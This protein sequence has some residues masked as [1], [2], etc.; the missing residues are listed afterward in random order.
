LYFT[1]WQLLFSL[2]AFLWERHCGEMGIFR[3]NLPPANRQR[4][5]AVVAITSCLFALA[6]WAYVLAFDTVGS[7]NAA[8]AIQVYPLFATGL[9][10]AFLRR[11]KSLVE[12]LFTLLIIAALFHLATGGE[13]RM[14]GVSPW[15]AVAL[16]VPTLWSIA[17]V[18]LRQVLV[19]TPITPH[20]VTCLRL[21]VSSLCLLPL[22]LAV[23]GVDAVMVAA[24]HG[25]AQAS[26]LLMGFVYYLELVLWFYAV[27]HID[28]SV[29][30]A[31]I[32]P[33]PAVTL[34]LT[35]F[36]LGGHA[37]GYQLVALSLVVVGLFGLL[38]AASAKSP[39]R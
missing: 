8:I 33:A 23:E 39:A 6:T 22:A 36:L 16:A 19:T 30:S 1:L 7:V 3:A 26:A 13:W 18:S 15:F 31:V 17:H 24:L 12:L 5:L 35:V 9:E 37:Q 4:A 21:A 25:P 34:G 28:I 14:A 10:A 27:R 29:A 38:R 11:R 20:Q 32:V 2:P